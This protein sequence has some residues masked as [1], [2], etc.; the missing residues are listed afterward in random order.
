MG[1]GGQIVL[2]DPTRA[3]VEVDLPDGVSLRDLGRHTL[4]DVPKPERLFQLDVPGLRTDF[5]P[6]RTGSGAVGNVPARLTSFVARDAELTTVADLLATAR[7]V[8]ITGP[9]G[10]GKSSLAA[11]AARAAAG[12]CPD[13]T[14]W[15]ALDGVAE[16]DLVPAAIA[17]ALGIY[18][19]PSSPVMERLERYLADRRALLVLDNFEHVLPAAP[20]VGDL[21]RA[22]PDLR[23]I[24]ASRAPLHVTGEQEFPLGRL[25]GT[26]GP[27][28]AGPSSGRSAAASLFVE[29]ARA[30]EPGW[31]PG[32]DE[33]VIEEICDLVDGLPLGIEL[34][35]ARVSRLP[36]AVIRDRLA[37]QLP[38]PG[39]GPRDAPA[40]QWTLD[41][42]IA[43]SY[44]LLLPSRR[45]LL[46]ELTVFEGGFDLEQAARVATIERGD[47]LMDAVYELV[48][49]SLV[50]R[51]AIAGGHGS[52]GSVRFRLLETIR[53]YALRRLRDEGDEVAVRQRH[54]LAMLELA[55]SAAKHLPSADQ[56]RWLDRLALDHANLGA[57]LRFATESGD[58]DVAQ[59]LSWATWRYWQ[60]GGHLNE[61]RELAD[62][63]VDMP[64]ADEPSPG[65]MWSLAAAGGLAYW[66]ADTS[67]ADELY[68]AQLET[69]QQIGDRAGEADATFNLAATR[70]IQGDREMGLQLVNRARELYAALGDTVAF[71]RTDWSLANLK[72]LSGETEEGLRLVVEAR[73]LYLENGDAMYEG[74]A[75]GS[76]A[77]FNQRMGN[78]PEAI[79]WGIESLRMTY[80][81][82]DIAT[83]TINLADGAILLI[84]VD[85]PEEAAV[86]LGAYHTLCDVHGVQPPAGIGRLIAWSGVEERTIASLSEATFAD[87]TRRGAAMSLDEAVAF[88]FE[89]LG[90]FAGPTPDEPASGQSSSE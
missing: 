67:H 47:D 18:D 73:E 80:A 59:R 34:A 22:A 16:L 90:P 13:G 88:A 36:P 77:F 1:H 66:Q 43:W 10:M 5:P 49:Q 3:L 6:I 45:R 63:V 68:L 12:A 69:S 60:F 74:L 25:A 40:R 38:L 27:V 44:D 33:A 87:A 76:I 85:R 57:A 28:E 65:R 23:I 14:W 19:G 55:E 4:K 39:T 83:A 61:G 31:D 58:V 70:S 32:A 37:A 81:L 62:A 89:T 35:A 9:G 56:V 42:T 53:S 54:A 29:R 48:D 2:S 24:V 52:L 46:R 78:I 64:R 26:D 20:L 7:L 30:V 71:A 15:V 51:S 17:R 86:L 79:R 82:R 11:E 21:L 75:A 84:E 41:G 72:V 8:T 50:V